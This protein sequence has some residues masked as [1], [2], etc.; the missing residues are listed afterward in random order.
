MLSATKQLPR[1]RCRR[2]QPGV[3]VTKWRMMK[4]RLVHNSRHARRAELPSLSI[5]VL[6]DFCNGNLQVMRCSIGHLANAMRNMMHELSVYVRLCSCVAVEASFQRS[7]QYCRAPAGQAR[8]GVLSNSGVAPVDS[9][10]AWTARPESR[11]HFV[12]HLC[13]QRCSW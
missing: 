8:G 1:H 12:S 3:I 13:L 10:R 2:Y 5:F 11:T 9:R 6:L 7:L 4:L